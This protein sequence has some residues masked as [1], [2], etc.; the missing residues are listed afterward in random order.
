MKTSLFAFFISILCFAF[1]APVEAA[2]VLQED[3]API[4][5]QE[6]K[7][8]RRLERKQEKIEQRID[9]WAKRIQKRQD[10]EDNTGKRTLGL[11]LGGALL[12]GGI[13]LGIIAFGSSLG[14]FFLFLSGLLVVGGIILLLFALLKKPEQTEG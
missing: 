7:A 3:I 5:K 4:S 8:Q 6:L 13:A 11:I 9:R 1:A 2:V 10:R 12:L 14:G